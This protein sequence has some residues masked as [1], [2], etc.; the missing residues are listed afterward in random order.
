MGNDVSP[1]KDSEPLIQL[2]TSAGIFMVPVDVIGFLISG[3]ICMLESVALILA[4][5]LVSGWICRKI[6]LPPLIGML[7]SGMVM[8]PY[9]L[10]VIDSSVLDIGTDLRQI[11]LIIILLRA[12]MNLDA[13]DLLKVGPAALLMCFVP[14]TCEIIG[15]TIFGVTLLG[16]NVSEGL[17]LGSVLAAV[18]PAVVVP[19]MLKIMEEGYGT[20]EGIPQV[21]LAGASADD[22]YVIVLFSC[23]TALAQSGHFNAETLMRIPTSIVLGILA[24]IAL[25]KVMDVVFDKVSFDLTTQLIILMTLSFGM[26][27]L[28]RVM[29][30]MIGFSGLL[31]IMAMGL[32]MRRLNLERTQDLS[33][34]LGSMWTCAQI[35]LFVLVG[36]VVDLSAVPSA[37][38]TI[39][40]VIAGGLLFRMA[41]TFMAVSASKFSMKE[42]LFCMISYTPKATVQAAIGAIPLSMGLACG[43]T[44]LTTAVMAILITAP[45]GALMIDLTYKRLLSH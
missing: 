4:A 22:I 15:V 42:K 3:G 8:G 13:Q 1:E 30:G 23:F 2:M 39:A 18:S 6:G 24:G 41:G 25:G 37:G 40:L 12:G 17:V 5:G 26:V 33:A 34:T 21:I 35:F 31:A 29:T 10:N 45:L 7:I 11:A 16:L 32:V 38:L 9:A 27:T 44:V 14:A 28:E 43:H 19:H 36:A 20:K